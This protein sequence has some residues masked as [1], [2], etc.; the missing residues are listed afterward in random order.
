MNKFYTFLSFFIV[1]TF[2]AQD[3][4]IL[5]QKTIGGSNMDAVQGL[6]VTSDGGYILGGYSNSNISGDKTENSRGGIDVW[7]VKTDALGN[8][9]WDKTYG[10]SGDDYLTSIKQ[11][12]DGGFIVGVGSNSNISGDKTENSRGGLDFWI[13]K[14]NAAGNIEWQKTYGGA[15]PDFDTYIFQTTDGGYFVSGYSD[16]NISGDKTVATNGQRDYWI[17]KLNATGDIVWQNSIGGSLLDRLI[18]SMQSQD[19]GYILGGHSDSNI[20]G[21]KSE[22]SRG[23]FDNWIVKLNPNGTI[24][25][26]KTYGGSDHDIVRDI[27]QTQDGNYIVGGYSHS[28]ISGDK[29]GE[30]RGIIDYWIYKLDTSGNMIWQKTIGGSQIDYLRTVREKPDGSLLVTGYS[31]SGISGDKTDESNG[32]YDMW[33]LLLDSGGEIAGQNTIGGSADESTGY[34]IILDDGY[35]F[36]V[37]TRSNISGDK[38]E[39]S[40]GVEDFWI[41][42][43]TNSLLGS[44][45]FESPRSLI[46]YPNPVSSTVNIQTI[47]MIHEINIYDIS[48]KLVQTEKNNSFSVE[49]FMPGIYLIQIETDK[50]LETVRIIKE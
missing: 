49:H 16:S 46:I 42:R 18:I 37:T 41:F 40:N 48:G 2:H 32:G 11:T 4:S 30:L 14:L 24:Q 28:G 1:V 45:N 27:I 36:A 29:T 17:L 12:S 31:N 25:W 50:G 44:P 15:Q 5:W 6:E 43:T 8:I 33:F 3:S 26:D 13:L 7:I 34:S 10:G 20:S 23:L 9:L 38:S 39:N 47:E 21:N 19:G 35:I 22:N